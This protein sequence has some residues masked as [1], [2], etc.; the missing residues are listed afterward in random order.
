MN[1]WSASPLFISSSRRMRRKVFTYIYCQ[2]IRADTHISVE[3]KK[4][5]TQSVNVCHFLLCIDL[6]LPKVDIIDNR[7]LL[8][9]HPISLISPLIAPHA[10]FIF[11]FFLIIVCLPNQKKILRFDCNERVRLLCVYSKTELASATADMLW[12]DLMLVTDNRKFV[13]VA[14]F[15]I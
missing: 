15:R 2:C 6:D 8:L 5:E 12:L 14:Q 9:A 10:H 13:D 11:F 3:W 4:K 7:L 1:L